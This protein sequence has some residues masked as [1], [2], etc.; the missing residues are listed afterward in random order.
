MAIYFSILYIR[1]QIGIVTD[2][3]L[4]LPKSRFVAIGILEALGVA[5]G[6][7]AGGTLL[8]HGMCYECIF[9]GSFV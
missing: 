1:Y 2:E 7:S 8:S 9:V 3:M 5:A 4:A 6:M